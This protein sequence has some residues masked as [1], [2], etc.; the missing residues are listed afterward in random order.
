MGSISFQFIRDSV[1]NGFAQLTDRYRIVPSADSR[2]TGRK[3]LSRA[4]FTHAEDAAL[5]N[6]VLAHQEDRRGNEIYKKFAESV[7]IVLPC[8]ATPV[9]CPTLAGF[10]VLCRCTNLH[11]APAPAS[12]SSMAIVEE[13][14][15]Q[16]FGLLSDRQIEKTFHV[17]SRPRC[18]NGTQA[19]KKRF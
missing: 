2:S 18:T 11:P 14:I 7:S 4:A 6:C 10:A 15:C 1:D 3:K 8:L 19:R 9:S 13:Q 17:G 16:G 12:I 5:A